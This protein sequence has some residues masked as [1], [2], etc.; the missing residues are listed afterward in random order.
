MTVFDKAY[1]P[2]DFV[3]FANPLVP[4]KPTPE[5]RDPNACFSFWAV[6]AGPQVRRAIADYAPGVLRGEH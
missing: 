3:D 2:C 1:L 4:A 5:G 6:S